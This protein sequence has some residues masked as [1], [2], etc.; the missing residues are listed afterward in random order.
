METNLKD[1]LLRSMIAFPFGVAV[2]IL[3]VVG[4]KRFERFF[5]MDYQGD[6]KARFKD[7]VIGHLFIGL[8]IG[9]LLPAFFVFQED[10][11]SW[12]FLSILPVSLC[13]VGIIV[14]I[15]VL[16]AY[17]R[18]YQ[19]NKLWAAY[20]NCSREIWLCSIRIHKAA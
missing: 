2:V 15:G 5:F 14:P 17:W 10:K 13:L 7:N 16:G 12:S 18:S 6:S 11:L 8:G 3:W 4:I 1:L 20:A 9:C 19:V